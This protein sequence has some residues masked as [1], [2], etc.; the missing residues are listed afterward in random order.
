MKQVLSSI[1]STSDEWTSNGQ[2]GSLIVDSHAG[3]TWQLELRSPAGNWIATDITFMD[4]GAKDFRHPAGLRFRLT[5][6][7]AGAE[8]WI[9]GAA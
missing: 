3:G 6:G 8:A 1:Q 7:T 2:I 5:G 4:V 9:V